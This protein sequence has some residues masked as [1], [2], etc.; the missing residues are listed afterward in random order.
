[1]QVTGGAGGKTG[2]DRL[3]GI[4]NL[5][6]NKGGILSDPRLTGPLTCG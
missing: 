6:G 2:A 5:Y 4:R 1:M 3:H